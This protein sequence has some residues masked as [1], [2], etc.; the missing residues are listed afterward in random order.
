[1]QEFLANVRL[2]QILDPILIKLWKLIQ[3]D[4]PPLYENLGE[5]SSY[6]SRA[7]RNK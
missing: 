5:R 1:M 4:K 6:C 2:S 3:Y 7:D